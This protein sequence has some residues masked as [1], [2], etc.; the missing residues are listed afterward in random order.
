MSAG[1]GF[2]ATIVDYAGRVLVTQRTAGDKLHM[3]LGH[4]ANG[5]YLLK[6]NKQAA[7]STHKVVIVHK[8]Q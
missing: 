8:L 6:I 2:S 5:V 7:V 4:L 3:A 1:K